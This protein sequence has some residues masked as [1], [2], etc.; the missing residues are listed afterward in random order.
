MSA[1][2]LNHFAAPTGN[3][4]LDALSEADQDVIRL[5]LHDVVLPQETVL[6]EQDN[7]EEE[8]YFPCRGSVSLI[9]RTANGNAIELA[10]V[11]R[12]GV[13][14]SLALLG[15]QHAFAT[16]VVNIELAAFRIPTRR[17]FELVPRTQTL[18]PALMADAERLLF[19]LRQIAGCN[20]L[21]PIEERLSRLLLGA[22][23][24]TGSNSI[25]LTQELMSQ[26]LGVQRTTV[27]LVIRMLA[28]AGAVRSR[29]GHV[30]IIDRAILERRSCECYG[31]IRDRLNRREAPMLEWPVNTGGYSATAA[32]GERRV[33]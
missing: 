6:C 21:H 18:A 10:S 33:E 23:D 2:Q 28:N 26:L 9:M 24:T 17:L 8:V 1:T 4:V 5:H 20:A 30:E 32:T 15:I 31:A 3:A 16:A 19:Q 22:A 7:K 25:P 11:G 29:R 13:L 12:R 27:N 14:G